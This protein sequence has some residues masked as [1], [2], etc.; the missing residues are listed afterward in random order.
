MNLMIL[1]SIIITAFDAFISLC[2]AFVIQICIFKLKV[3]IVNLS[4]HVSKQ[5]KNNV[6]Q[7]TKSIFKYNYCL[8]TA[9]NSLVM[10]LKKLVRNYKGELNYAITSFQF[11]KQ[12][13]V[14]IVNNE[15]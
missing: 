5:N 1:R 8:E 2:L 4:E 9:L 7:F 6:F 12:S 13:E 11:T 3:L 10:K 15:N 14:L